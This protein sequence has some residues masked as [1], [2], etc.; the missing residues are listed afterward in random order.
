[1]TLKRWSIADFPDS[2][3]EYK[4]AEG[5]ADQDTFIISLQISNNEAENSASIEF[6]F[7]DGT[8][9][10]NSWSI[11]KEVGET[12]TILDSVI[13]LQPGDEVWCKSDQVNCSIRANGEVR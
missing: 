4:L 1:M 2:E 6:R 10:Q 7:S 13:V 5:E 3:T 8:D 12:P 9:T 11:E